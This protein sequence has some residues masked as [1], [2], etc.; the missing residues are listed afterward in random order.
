MT[1]ARQAHYL[2]WCK[3]NEIVDPVGSNDGWQMVL[4][5]YGKFVMKGISTVNKQYMRSAMVKGYVLDAGK[6]LH[7][8]IS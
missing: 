4:A 7:Y 6:F 8:E 5:I 3:A 1:R 2:K